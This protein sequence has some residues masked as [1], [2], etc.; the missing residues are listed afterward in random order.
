MQA[1]YHG[2]VSANPSEP[3]L[4]GIDLGTS[5]V[6]VLVAT[7]GGEVLGRGTAQYPISRPEADRAE[8]DPEAWWRSIVAAT[9][10][11][12]ELADRAP[13]GRPAARRVASI[14][15]AGQM[16]GT[17]LLSAAHEVLAPA[18]IWP[19]QRS[20]AE[21]AAL[22]QELGGARVLQL[23]GGPLATGFQAATIR[24]LRHHN[25]GLLDRASVILAPKDAIRLR[26]TAEVASEPS[27]GSGTGMLDPRTRNWSAELVGAVG[28]DPNLLPPLVESTAVAGDLRSVAAEDL[29]LQ[30]G[31]PVVAGGADTPVGM[32][33]AGLVSPD[34]FLLTISSGGQLA[35]PSDAPD[36]DSTGRSHTFCATLPR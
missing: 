16:H 11:A 17:V 5:S 26:M 15:F 25:P 8:Q 21:V 3:L 27:D 20:G 30:P 18:I 31:I 14:A 19:D 12:V 29:G 32:L 2:L 33:G 9:R 7:P 4:L 24:W 23:A 35:V 34:E 28:V 10:S 13:G 1:Q 22:A 6:K 36:I